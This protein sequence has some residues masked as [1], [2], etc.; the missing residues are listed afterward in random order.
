MKRLVIAGNWKMHKTFEETDDFLEELSE[1]IDDQRDNLGKVDVIV[2]P[3]FVYL[4]MATDFAD[5]REFFI[6]AQNVSEHEQG[7]YTGEISAAMLE[8]LEADFCI[9]G[10][11]ERRKYHAEGDALINA[12]VKALQAHKV[13]P[14][15]CIGETEQERAEGKT[16]DVLKRQFDGCFEGID[17]EQGFLIAYEPVWAIGTGNT[18]TPAQA[19]EA[20]AFIRELLLKH[21]GEEITNTIPI[22]YGGSV[23]P[24][25][26]EELMVQQ[27]IDGALIGGAS[28]DIA[29]FKAMIESAIKLSKK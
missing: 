12:K 7:A 9:V 14:I 29:K 8:S 15:V 19:Q 20:H 13:I 26:I 5:E 21:F 11:S 24:A 28:L 25:N 1:F 10:H 16:F 4:E 6:G 27:D 3:P 2:C 17:A 18:A 23:T 22:L